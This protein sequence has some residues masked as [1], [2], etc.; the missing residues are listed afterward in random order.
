MDTNVKGVTHVVANNYLSPA[1][2][3]EDGHNQAVEFDAT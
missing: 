3:T 1:K 2:T